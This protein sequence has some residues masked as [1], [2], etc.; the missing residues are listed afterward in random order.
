MWWAASGVRLRKGSDWGG[1]WLDRVDDRPSQGKYGRHFSP[2][3]L[4]IPLKPLI[5]EE[6]EPSVQFSPVFLCNLNPVLTSGTT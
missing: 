2:P 1:L 6:S 4:S 5:G 3:S